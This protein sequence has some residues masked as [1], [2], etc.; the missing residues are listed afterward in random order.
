[1]THILASGSGGQE[2]GHMVA[3]FSAQGLTRLNLRGLQGLWSHLR[4]GVLHQALWLL[5]E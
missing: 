5:A 1:M 3:G 4:F 2:S